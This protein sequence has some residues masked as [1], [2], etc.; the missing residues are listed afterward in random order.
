M[1]K[2][3]CCLVVFLIAGSLFASTPM[4]FN[5]L[6]EYDIKGI[7]YDNTTVP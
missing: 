1:R 3:L 6:I 7:C 5:T 4:S 2:F